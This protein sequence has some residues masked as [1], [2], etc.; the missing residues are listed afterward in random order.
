MIFYSSLKI[1]PA[2]LVAVA[3]FAWLAPEAQSHPVY[4][5]LTTIEWNSADN[6]LEIILE[7]QAHELA[8]ALQ[9]TALTVPRVRQSHAPLDR[10]GQIASLIDKNIGLKIAGKLVKP[11]FIGSETVGSNI[12]VYLEADWPSAPPS[13]TYLNTLF[14]DTQRGQINSVIVKVAGKQQAAEIDKNTGPITFVFG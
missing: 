11:A 14:L 5:S 1:W 6:S 12:F 9:K 7:I 10:A 3:M 2:L 4:T 8:D 13:I